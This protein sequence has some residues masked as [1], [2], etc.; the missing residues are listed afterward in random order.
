MDVKVNSVAAVV[1]TYNRRNLLEQALGSLLVQTRPINR[2]YIVDNASTDGTARYLS[3]LDSP[4]ISFKRL[5]TNTGG[6][7]GFSY[8]MK[9]AFDEGHEWIWLMDDDIEQTPRCLETL[10]ELGTVAKVLLPLATS[11]KGEHFCELATRLNL[12]SPFTLGF[13]LRT[14]KSVYPTIESLP[15][16]IP[17]EDLTFEAPLIHR[18]VPECIGFPRADFF[19]GCDDTEYGV[20]IVRAKLGP[21]LVVKEAVMRR[22]VSQSG[23]YPPWRLYYQLRNYLITRSCYSVPLLSFRVRLMFIVRTVFGCLLRQD[24]LLTTRIRIHALLDSLPGVELTRRYL[25]G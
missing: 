21:I 19:I 16:V 25:P 9:W 3:A 14:V 4:R 5:S 22:L 7:G 17:L 23:I 2:I 10:L 8:G 1:V 11:G 24:S 6:A 15:A 18:S 20:R 12:T 13:K